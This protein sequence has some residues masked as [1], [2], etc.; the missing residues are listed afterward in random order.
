MM[1][2]EMRGTCSVQATWRCEEDRY[3]SLERERLRERVR[4]AA[5]RQA[6]ARSACSVLMI[7]ST[8][9]TC[10]GEIQTCQHIEHHST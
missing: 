7:D 2:D 8:C 3:D 4:A 10:Q 1:I 5:G 6:G 9:A